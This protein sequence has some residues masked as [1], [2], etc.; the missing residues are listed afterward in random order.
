VRPNHSS[1]TIRMTLLALIAMLAASESRG[2]LG[3]VCSTD[4]TQDPELIFVGTVVSQRSSLLDSPIYK[5]SVQNVEYG[6]AIDSIEIH[7]TGSDCGSR[8]L[9]GGVYRVSADRYEKYGDMYF[10][11]LCDGNKLIEAPAP[12]RQRS[13]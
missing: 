13:Q 10:T 1:S 3:C 5:F 2:A 8:F 9:V 6:E 7:T 4:S 12:E 11:G